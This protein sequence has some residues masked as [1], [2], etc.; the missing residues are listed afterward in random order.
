MKKMIFLSRNKIKNTIFLLLTIY[1]LNIP[2]TLTHAVETNIN[3]KVDNKK[4][5]MSRDYQKAKKALDYATNFVTYLMYLFGTIFFIALPFCSL[6]VFWDARKR[7]LDILDAVMWALGTLIFIFYFLPKWFVNRPNF[8]V[9][10]RD[11]CKS[12]NQI[13]QGK[14]IVCPHCGYTF[15]K[16]K[17][18][19]EGLKEEEKL[20]AEIKKIE[21][22]EK[23]K[24]DDMDDIVDIDDVWKGTM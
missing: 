21:E 16:T 3:N 23:K 8:Y 17:D 11:V 14:P 10:T 13:Y 4:L 5:E 19:I 24:K 18:V 1:I 20:E 9:E 6:F 2:L 7:G 15:K 22:S 12:C